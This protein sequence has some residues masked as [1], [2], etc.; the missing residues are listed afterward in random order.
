[1]QIFYLICLF[2]S[3]FGFIMGAH[4][5]C[6]QKG[7]TSGSCNKII[8]GYMYSAPKRSCFSMSMKGC[9]ARG[10]FFDKKSDCNECL[11]K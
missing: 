6:S 5:R 1:M 7:G 9:E 10:K 8:H 11:S 3:L 4:V 2:L